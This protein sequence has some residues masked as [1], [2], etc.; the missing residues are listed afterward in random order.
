M[1][2]KWHILLR[3]IER[4]RHRKLT[5]YFTFVIFR[6]T[7]NIFMSQSDTQWKVLP[8]GKL[9]KLDDII[10]TVTGDLHVPMKLPRR[11]T[12]VRLIDSRLV[13]Y[14]AIALDTGGMAAI[15]AFGQPAFLIVPSDK[16]RRDAR[17]WKSRYPHMQVISPPGAR[18]K[19]EKQLEVDTTEPSFGD[20]NVKFVIVPGTNAREC[21]LI[22]RSANGYT[23]V[24]ND[25]VG[26]IT[27]ANGLGGWLLRMA[28]FAGE[29]AQIPRVVMMSLIEDRAALRTQLLQ[30]AEI[31]PL[32][33]ILVAHGSPIDQNPR[34]ILR[35][36]ASSLGNPKQAGEPLGSHL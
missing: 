33:R 26:N 15:E 10:Q 11:M 19:V 27:N 8:H 35:D 32:N 20:V 4:H 9:S 7:E 24:L 16:H 30:W 21:A 23:L 12:V 31:E 5:T 18:S 36:L 3:R 29:K 6:T 1:R 14:S 34:Q 2:I 13:I 17:M 22:V 28:G 25:L